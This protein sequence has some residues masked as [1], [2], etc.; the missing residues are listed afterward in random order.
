MKTKL[1]NRLLAVASCVPQGAYLCDVGTDHAYLPI[2]LAEEGKLSGAIASDIHK[3][4]LESA[5]KNIAEAGFSDLIQTAL[6]DG[7]TGLET[8]PITDIAICGMG[9]QMIM[10]ILEKA[11]FLREKKLRLILQPMQHIPEL[12]VYLAKNGYRIEKELQTMAEGKFYQILC[13]VYDANAREIDELTSLLGAY[14]I[15]HKSENKENFTLLCEKHLDIL[16]E[17]IRGLEKGGKDAS[18]EKALCE[19]IRKELAS[20]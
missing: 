3:G 5:E 16:G 7:L 2:H 8:Y 18:R 12:R 15:A 1:D 14:N 6:C 11:P 19:K 9:G 10:G 20:I 17:R 13:A 4:P